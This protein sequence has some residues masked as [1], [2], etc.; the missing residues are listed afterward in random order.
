MSIQHLSKILTYLSKL[1]DLFFAH[2]VITKQGYINIVL[3][4]K[5]KQGVQD[6]LYYYSHTDQIVWL[7]VEYSIFVKIAEPATKAI[8]EARKLLQEAKMSN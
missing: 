6:I 7:P 8:I 2:S 4:I 3:S 5:T 1:S